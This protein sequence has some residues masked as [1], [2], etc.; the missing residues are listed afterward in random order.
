MLWR[1]VPSIQCFRLNK[2]TSF[3]FLIRGQIRRDNI[4]ANYGI[5]GQHRDIK[6]WYDSCVVRGIKCT[7][8]SLAVWHMGHFSWNYK[9][10]CSSF[11][12]RNAQKFKKRLWT[13][14]RVGSTAMKQTQRISAKYPYSSLVPIVLHWPE[15]LSASKGG[16]RFDSEFIGFSWDNLYQASW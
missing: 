9:R 8:I 13:Y 1:F 16:T 10:F 6:Y 3:V 15:W 5:E 12:H 11:T 14:P 2:T 4:G 7:H